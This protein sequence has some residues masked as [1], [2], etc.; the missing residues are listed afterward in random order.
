MI[1]LKDKSK[2]FIACQVKIFKSPETWFLLLALLCSFGAG[3]AHGQER[4]EAMRYGKEVILQKDPSTKISRVNIY[5]ENNAMY[6]AWDRKD[7][8]DTGVYVIMQSDDGVSFTYYAFIP[9]LKESEY[10]SYRL[11]MKNKRSFYQVLYISNHNTYTLSERAYP[12]I[13]YAALLP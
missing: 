13:Y 1:L 9:C 11:N 5:Y 8:T 4:M 7:V 2:N 12:A 3:I 6:L 10:F